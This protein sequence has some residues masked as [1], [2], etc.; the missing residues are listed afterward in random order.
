[1]TYTPMAG[2]APVTMAGC[3]PECEHVWGE[4]IPGDPRGGSG[5]PTDKNNRGEGYGR[6]SGRGNWC[7]RCGGWRGCLGLEPTVSMYVAHIVLIFREV[8]RVLRDDGTLWLNLGDSYSGAGAGGG[9]NRKD[10]EHGQHDAMIG[11][12][13]R[14][15][16][17]AGLKPKDLCMIPAR[18][19]LA[20]QADGWWLRSDPPWLKDNAMPESVR[21][22]PTKA[23]EYVFLLAKSERYFYDHEAVKIESVTG[24]VRRPYTSAGAWD[25]DG[26]PESQRHGGEPRNGPSAGITR[27]RRTTDWYDYDAAIRAHKAYIHHLERIR[28]D[29]GMLT[30]FENG[31][32]IA[33]H[34]NPRGYSGAHFAT[35]PPDLVAPMIRAGTSQY[36]VCPECG[37]PWKRV[38][39]KESRVP[40]EM[41]KKRGASRGSLERGY[42]EN[43][44]NR[45]DHTLGVKTE[46][47]GW[48]PTCDHDADPIPAVV[49]DPF[50]G[51][52][53]VGEVCRELGR[54]LIGLDLNPAYL[55]DL[56]L[57]RAENK[58]T[59]ASLRTMPLFQT[60]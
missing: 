4:E 41:R 44:G 14:G 15:N 29:S 50:C 42:N 18:V 52:G 40:W 28:D 26:R 25:L 47:L 17:P 8:W 59:A 11:L 56:A 34:V 55:R 31:M 19:A 36:G 57:P 45:T 5:T 46:T 20:L 21:D 54:K 32:P 27:N 9:G 51:S 22:R 35:F 7:Q 38:V 2:L 30:D 10:N 33:F 48:R 24:E 1:V 37:A 49:L 12:G 60:D 13:I 43:H 3:D 16:T 23:H 58:Q 39:K 6:D 53:T